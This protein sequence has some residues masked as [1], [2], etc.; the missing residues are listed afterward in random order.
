M[1][2]PKGKSRQQPIHPFNTFGV[3]HEDAISGPSAGSWKAS[4]TINISL[5]LLIILLGTVITTGPV[6][7]S[8]LDLQRTLGFYATQALMVSIVLFLGWAAWQLKRR[9]QFGYG[10]TEVCFAGVSTCRA[11]IGLSRGTFDLAHTILILGCVY[12]AARGI[13]NMSEGRRESSARPRK[14]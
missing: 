1:D 2:L 9:K 7:K 11:T 8:Y 12:I 6:S 5:A 4:L 14:A 10:L 3:I 13:S